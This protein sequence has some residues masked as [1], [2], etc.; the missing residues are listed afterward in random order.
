MFVMSLFFFFFAA[1]LSILF[2]DLASLPNILDGNEETG[3]LKTVITLDKVTDKGII[4][5]CI[6]ED[7]KLLDFKEFLVGLCPIIDTVVLYIV[8]ISII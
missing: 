8:R 4:E 3:Y 6:S 5:R 1:E 2:T 7:I